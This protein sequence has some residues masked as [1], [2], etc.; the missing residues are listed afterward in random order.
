[1]ENELLLCQI[2]LFNIFL[3]LFVWI[4]SFISMGEERSN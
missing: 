4:L 1:M 2:I 3:E